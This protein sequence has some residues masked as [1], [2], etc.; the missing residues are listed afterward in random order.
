ML[1]GGVAMVD[2]DDAGNVGGILLSLFG[3]TP[4]ME[5]ISGIAMLGAGFVGAATWLALMVLLIVGLTKRPLPSAP[6]RW[7]SP[8]VVPYP[9]HQPPT[10]S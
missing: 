4:T 6:P 2:G 9:W 3:D 1:V 7:A 8:P 10:R 5:T